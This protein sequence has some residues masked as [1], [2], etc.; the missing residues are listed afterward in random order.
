FGRRAAVT[1]GFTQR[2]ENP[3][4]GQEKTQAVPNAASG[5]SVKNPTKGK[6]EA[7]V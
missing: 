5:N 7:K 6:L 1:F 3:A 2:W 4:G